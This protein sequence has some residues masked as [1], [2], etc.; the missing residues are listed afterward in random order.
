[1]RLYLYDT[2]NK[3]DVE[4]LL[5]DIK[6]INSS[7]LYVVFIDKN[8]I[9][10]LNS[11][12]NSFPYDEYFPKKINHIINASATYENRKYNFT[13]GYYLSENEFI[14]FLIEQANLNY[15]DELRFNNASYYEEAHYCTYRI[16]FNYNEY[17]LLSELGLEKLSFKEYFSKLIN[18]EIAKGNYKLFSL[19]GKKSENFIT[20]GEL[21]I[22]FDKY[23]KEEN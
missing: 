5:E 4:L 22:L 6:V 2:K 18:D 23:E 15:A 7:D 11:G 21:S 3:K 1:M 17:K 19:T 14:P 9:C 20:S 8:I 12:K 13:I 16:V 10:N